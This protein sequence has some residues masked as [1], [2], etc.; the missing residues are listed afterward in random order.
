[1]KPQ[2]QPQEPGVD[3][4]LRPEPVRLHSMRVLVVGEDE[5]LLATLRTS[6]VSIAEG[7]EALQSWL[8]AGARRDEPEAIIV[9]TDML[10]I[11]SAK[12]CLA[13]VGPDR[14]VALHG[15][16][17]VPSSLQ[18]AAAQ[19]GRRCWSTDSLDELRRF[20]RFAAALHR[21]GDSII[22]HAVADLATR[23]RVRAYQAQIMAMGAVDAGSDVILEALGVGT[24]TLKTHV[25]ELLHLTGDRHL[26]SLGK[27]V[28]HLALARASEHVLERA[29]R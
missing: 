23:R 10:G 25:R 7:V 5:D 22:A 16:G 26:D 18:K 24:N 6:H 14:A 3:N 12:R 11:R 20:L 15:T 28:L 2:R 27:R 4:P 9:A 29:S 13:E 19:H 1:M 17:L 21:C 8:V